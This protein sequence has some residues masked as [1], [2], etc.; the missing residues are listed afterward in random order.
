MKAEELK[1]ILE[2]GEGY[3]VEFKEKPAHIDR[4]MV[5]FANG[6]GGRIFIGISDSGKI[7]GIKVT[8]QLKSQIQDIIYNVDNAMLFLRQH[9]PVRYEFDGSPKR[10]EIPQVPL[11]ALREA[12][13]KAVCHRYYFEKGANVMVEIFDG[14]IEISSPGGLVKGLLEK[15][16]GKKSVLRNPKIAGLFHRIGYIEKMGTGI[17]RMQNLMKEAGLPPIRFEFTTFVTAVFDRGVALEKKGPHIKMNEG[18]NEGLKSLLAVIS[19]NPGIQ[20]KKASA[21]LGK[22]S[23]KTLE[24]QIQNLVEKELIEHRGSKKT[25]GYFFKG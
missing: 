19:Q 23:V 14:R 2:E 20:I 22:R 1:L 17:Q 5:A 24:K 13:I 8:N 6:S 21:L 7:K 3:L 12:V 4:E 9:I 10:I 18:L 11:E 15:D 16:F 25:G